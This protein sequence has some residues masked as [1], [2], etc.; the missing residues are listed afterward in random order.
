M[1]AVGNILCVLLCGV[2][3]YAFMIRILGEKQEGKIYRYAK[4]DTVVVTE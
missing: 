2:M 4:A 3:I 1:K